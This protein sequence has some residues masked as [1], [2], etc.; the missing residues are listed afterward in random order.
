MTASF[1]WHRFL[2]GRENGK[3]LL[4][5]GVTTSWLVICDSVPV[6]EVTTSRVPRARVI[7]VSGQISELEEG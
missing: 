1:F 2:M 6:V 7:R 4:E 3:Q 5:E